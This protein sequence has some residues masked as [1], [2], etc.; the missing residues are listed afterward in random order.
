MALPCSA[1][2][3]WSVVVIEYKNLN[4]MY[5]VKRMLTVFPKLLPIRQALGRLENVVCGTE[6]LDRNTMPCRC[7]QR[8]SC[9]SSGYCSRRYSG[10]GYMEPKLLYMVL[11]MVNL[12]QRNVHDCKLYVKSPIYNESNQA[13]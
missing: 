11:Q 1:G 10:L 5:L 12:M 13:L 3:L 6:R 4:Y 7:L 9:K 2:F 8:C